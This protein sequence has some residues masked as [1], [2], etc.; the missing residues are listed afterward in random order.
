MRSS[1]PAI[2][3]CRPASFNASLDVGPRREA[4]QRGQAAVRARQGAGA[5][6]QRQSRKASSSR[7]ASTVLT[8]GRNNFSPRET[9]IKRWQFA[10]TVDLRARARTRLKGG[11]DLQFDDI[12]NLFPG[13][14]GGSYTFSSLAS[15]AGGRPNGRERVLPAELSPAPGPTGAATHPNIHEYSFF[16]QDEWRSA[17]DLTRQRRPALRPDEDDRAAGAESRSTARRGR[18]R[19]QPAGEPTRTTGGRGSGWRGRLKDA[20]MWSAAAGDSSTAGRLDHARHRPL[21]QRHQHVAL[22]FTG[23]AVPTYPQRFDQIPA[24]GTAAVRASST[25]T[26]SSR[27][28]G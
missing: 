4:V 11:F 26:K 27:T 22:T 1:T 19:H 8:I 15:F 25:S 23:D 6:E 13:F 17:S 9:T 12:L 14:F 28:R 2:R 7:A 5:G 10:D 21:E 20:A 16:V 3:W 24:V 18:H